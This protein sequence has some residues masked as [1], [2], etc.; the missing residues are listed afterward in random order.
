MR[1]PVMIEMTE[2]DQALKAKK[3]NLFTE[4]ISAQGAFLATNDP[5]PQGTRVKAV[6]VL[7]QRTSKVETRRI[8]HVRI[9]GTVVRTE[10]RGM[11]VGFDKQYK[12]I[13]MVSSL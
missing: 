8:V 2:G 4:N 7:D 3:V 1:L 5:F 11:A 6:L 12:I 10:S 9:S 13:S